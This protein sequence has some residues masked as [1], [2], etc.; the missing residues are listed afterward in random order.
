MDNG[1]KE[2]FGYIETMQSNAHNMRINGVI[3]SICIELNVNM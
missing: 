2:I 1:A 3:Y